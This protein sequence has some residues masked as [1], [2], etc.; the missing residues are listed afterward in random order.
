MKSLVIVLLVALAALGFAS[1]ALAQTQIP[2]STAAPAP[3]LP[4][5][6]SARESRPDR[7][8]TSRSWDARGQDASASDRNAGNRTDDVS[9]LPRAT[10]AER[11][12][13]F[14]LS[15]TSAIVIAAGLLVVVVLA[16]I[17][18]TRSDDTYFDA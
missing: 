14:G 10:A 2:G 7:T 3:G 6:T 11:T 18:M 4:D 9:A 12:T 8:D 13:L 15:P 1:G 17:A 5:R 16:I